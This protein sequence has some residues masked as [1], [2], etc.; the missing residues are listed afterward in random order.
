[1]GDAPAELCA[2]TSSMYGSMAVHGPRQ[3]GGGPSPPPQT[4]LPPPQ[5]DAVLRVQWVL[6]A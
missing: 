1:M 3:V 4:P 6:F 2:T 5:C